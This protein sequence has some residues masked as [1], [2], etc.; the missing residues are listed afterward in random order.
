MA[1]AW[2]TSWGGSRTWCAEGTVA[3]GKRNPRSAASPLGLQRAQ[4]LSESLPAL[5]MRARRI[6]ASISHGPHGRRR[7]GPGEEFWQYRPYMPGDSAALVDWRK[8]AR[9]QR[10]FVRE[11]EWMA[12]NSLWLWVQLD[13]GMQWR[14]PLAPEDKARRALLLALALARLAQRGGERIAALGAP[15]SPDHAPAA[16][17][18]MALWWARRHDTPR[19]APGTEDERRLPPLVALPRFSTCVLIG[20]FFTDPQALVRRL[21]QLAAQGARGHLLQVVDPAEETFPFTGRVRFR[22]PDSDL[23][24]LGERAEELRR[25]YH[26]AL[27]RMRHHLREEARKVGW[28]FLAHRTDASPQATLL[29][30]L[31]RL[32]MPS[33]TGEGGRAIP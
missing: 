5:V 16:L 19:H 17:E 1:C 23:S 7:T 25:D 14:S 12:A 11:T 27:R 6:A 31:A 2:K 18:R 22:A 9:A 29:A 10:V 8:S 24:V 30:L 3:I 20:D 4:A 32:G 26:H 21:R 15:F 28:T 33:A 13:A